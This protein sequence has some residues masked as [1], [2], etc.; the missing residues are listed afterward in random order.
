MR[1]SLLLLGAVGVSGGAVHP[2]LAK[3]VDLLNEMKDTID[4]DADSDA[5]VNEKMECWCNKNDQALSEA[6]E[7]TQAK[8]TMLAQNVITNTAT[9]SQKETE[10]AQAAKDIQRVKEEQEQER[11]RN[12]EKKEKLNNDETE[13]T[14]AVN[15][16]ENAITILSKHNSAL[17][18]QK[19]ILSLKKHLKSHTDLLDSLLPNDREVVLGFLQQ[20]PGAR[21]PTEKKGGYEGQSGEIFGILGEMKSQFAENLAQ[22]KA[23]QVENRKFSTENMHRL[24][25][26][27]VALTQKE[28]RCEET[29]ARARSD[30]V[31]D[32]ASIESL[33]LK[34]S[35]D[36]NFLKTVKEK[37]PKHRQ[38][39]EKRVKDRALEVEAIQEATN[40]L[41]GEEAHK[42]FAKMNPKVGLFLQLSATSEQKYTRKMIQVILNQ[43]AKNG[44]H[45]LQLTQLAANSGLDGF[46]KVKRAI[47]EMMDALDAQRKEEVE[48]KDNCVEELGENAKQ[49]AD[50]KHSIEAKGARVA[51]LDARKNEAD[52]E[53]AK[54]KDEEKALEKNKEDLQENHKE[55]IATTQQSI[56]DNQAAITLLEKALSALS[57]Q[58]SKIGF[59]QQA[60]E[61]DAG[62]QALTHTEAPELKGE[63]RKAQSGGAV[64]VMID[65]VIN[66]AKR[67]INDLEVA[68]KNDN[69]DYASE[70]EDL[71]GR[72]SENR[73]S[74]VA[75]A[76]N[77]STTQEAIDEDN[78]KIADKTKES[79]RVEEIGVTLH[80]K[81][82]FLVKHFQP[83]QDA[84]QEE[85]SALQQVRSILGGATNVNPA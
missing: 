57:M 67:E 2:R 63:Y 6:Q 85:I 17:N 68:R 46:E 74:Q 71:N 66:D 55:F 28:G 34:S 62:R 25:E 12:N 15:Q 16:L 37:C 20:T 75:S 5:R 24:G 76:L 56:A 81:C 51:Q 84:I 13:L 7:A 52:T 32:N 29:C 35:Q 30:L 44:P 82:D 70:L 77:S 73:S 69:D 33:R 9:I 1:A 22:V 47:T 19:A 41:T 39:Y 59:I 79:M 26:E 50:V 4:A 83:R 61:P 27:L 72:L 11:S 14:L 80:L 48:E 31:N 3:I 38:E 49:F 40:F 54:L 45:S 8:L 21:E 23:D 65:G 78:G 58:Y 10:L 64:L 36:L 53:L 18:Q 42:I 43:A 60:Q